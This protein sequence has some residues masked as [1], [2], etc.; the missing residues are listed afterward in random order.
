M[1]RA[2]TISVGAAM[3]HSNAAQCIDRS[4]RTPVRSVLTSDDTAN[5]S[6]R[7]AASYD[8]MPGR[9]YPHLA[10]PPTAVIVMC[11]IV[12]LALEPCQCRSPA[13]MCTTS[14]TLISCGVPPS[15]ATMPEPEVTTRIWSHV[16]VCQPVVQPWLKLTTLQL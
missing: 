10:S 1:T 8:L 16:C 13:L 12:E 3:T 4:R 14:P 11:P 2:V 6:R 15:V 7:W 5:R 9:G